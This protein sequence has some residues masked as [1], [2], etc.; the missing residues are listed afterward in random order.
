MPDHDQEVTMDLKK[1]SL[2]E[3]ILS[4]AG[5]IVIIDLLFLPWHHISVRLSGV[6]IASANRSGVSS[7]NG[8]LGLL[9][10]LVAVAIVAHIVVSEFT[11]VELPK[12]PVTWGQADLIGAAVVAALLVLKLVLKTDFLGFGAWLG[13]ISAGALVYGGVRRLQETQAPEGQATPE[14][15]ATG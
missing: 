2:G 4:A 12:L 8:F 14:S 5:I 10:L 13:V 9:A 7:P 1:L 6:T 15:S 3:R 11:K